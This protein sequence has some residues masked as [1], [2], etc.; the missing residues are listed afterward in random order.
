MTGKSATYRI[1]SAA[2]LALPLLTG[3]TF[4][5]SDTSYL[6]AT[7]KG[8]AERTWFYLLD[9][10]AVRGGRLGD[11]GILQRFHPAIDAEHELD[12]VSSR[13]ELGE[14]Y[15]WEHRDNG[16][17]YWGGS[18][19]HRDLVEGAAFKARV[20]LGRGWTIYPRYDRETGPPV[21]RNLVRLGFEKDW[22][23]IFAFS[24]GSLFA[25]KP[26]IDLTLGAGIRIRDGELRASLTWLDSF[27]DAIYQGLVV[28]Y[29]FADTAI[30]YEEQEFALRL[31][32]ERA[33]GRMRLET[34][35]AV[36]LPGRIR[37]YRQLQPDQG[38]RQEERFA[39]AGALAEWSFSP[40]LRAGGLLTW[41][42]AATDRTPL[43]AGRALDDYRLVE[44]TTRY[45]LYLLA[46]PHPRW[47]LQSWLMREARP[48]NRIYRNGAAPA[49]DYEDRSWQSQTVLSYRAT[50][51]FFAS[52]SFETD[53]RDVL[54]GA[55]Q[56]PSLEPLGQHNVR[57][58][59]ELGW[60][61]GRNVMLSGG[62]RMDLDGDPGTGHGRF[63]GAH[64]KFA[65]YW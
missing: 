43:A 10:A 39:M 46:W 29:G 38:F 22:G 59:V 37:A 30:D 36:L 53:L 5:Q 60:R 58:R 6:H 14:E 42:R 26:D 44:R 4:A 28:W 50:G 51:G 11:R 20:P 62:Y 8:W 13:L 45:G 3:S 54:K 48:E 34:H 41:V 52:A 7:L 31:S 24:E 18:I 47:L 63:D 27:N 16:S 23:R 17:H 9:R 2:F 65:V 21:F 19:N 25:T 49:V 32:A 1:L 35:G 64:G 55:G 33:M 56:V 57:V 40:R 15:E 12:L 61:L